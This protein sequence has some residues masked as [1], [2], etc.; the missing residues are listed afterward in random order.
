MDFETTRAS[1]SGMLYRMLGF[2]A[3]LGALA[4]ILAWLT[5]V[6]LA[7][8]FSDNLLTAVGW[9]ILATIPMLLMMIWFETSRLDW[10]V[11]S[12]NFVEQKLIPLFEGISAGGIFLI[13]LFAGVFE[14]L[15][16]RGVIQVGLE[17]L[18]GL[19]PALLLTS[20]LFGLAHA[21]TRTYFVI[22]AL[23]GLYFGG[24][25]VWTD[26]LLVPILAH[27]LYDWAVF[28]WLLRKRAGSS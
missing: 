15:L 20:L 21:M 18:L 1:P 6:S 2:E 10:L 19:W 17:G 22:T 26:N 5:G 11:E 4:L 7:T 27:F 23:M 9:G 3:A 8:A 13:A 12:R 28:V 24:L 16:F 14:E 25:Y